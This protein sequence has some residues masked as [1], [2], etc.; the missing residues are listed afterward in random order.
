M[1]YL[2]VLVLSVINLLK[3]SPTE[4]YRLQTIA[5][6]KWEAEKSSDMGFSFRD[7]SDC[8]QA[9]TTSHVSYVTCYSI[10]TL[11]NLKITLKY[12]IQG[13][14]QVIKSL[15]NFHF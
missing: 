15:S 6:N 5:W 13:Y 7:M 12:K 8:I 14:V 10:T 3:P 4:Y 9:I 2:T 1:N 11:E